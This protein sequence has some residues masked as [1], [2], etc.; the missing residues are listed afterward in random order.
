[1]KADEFILLT[2][3]RQFEILLEKA[4]VVASMYNYSGRYFLFQLDDFY[5]ELKAGLYDDTVIRMVCFNG[6]V[7]LDKYLDQI[8]ISSLF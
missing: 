8:D 2:L 3:P 5:I 1:M 4:V 7:G 6:T